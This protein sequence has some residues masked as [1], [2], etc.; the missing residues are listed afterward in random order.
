[1]RLPGWPRSP[2]SAGG[3]CLPTLGCRRSLTA[4]MPWAVLLVARSSP[5]QLLSGEN[6]TRL[7]A[8][9]WPGTAHLKPVRVSARGGCSWFVR[10]RLA[11]LAG[12]PRPCDLREPCGMCASAVQPLELSPAGLEPLDTVSGWRQRTEPP[13][14][15]GDPVAG[16]ILAVGR[17]R[18]RTHWPWPTPRS[19]CRRFVQQSVEGG[20]QRVDSGRGYFPDE[21]VVDG[22][23]AVYQHIAE[24]DDPR[25]VLDARCGERSERLS[26]LSASP[27][28]S[29]WRAT[30]D[31]T[32]ASLW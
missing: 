6:I 26:R 29:N 7:S 30:A 19:D 9:P 8:S 17:R 1:M 32:I 11:D 13:V 16:T 3:S 24:G 27:M 5:Y 22:G 25:Q 10:T 12:R 21:N 23:V 18:L 14:M 31:R 15:S 4:A 2:P 28:I 20:D